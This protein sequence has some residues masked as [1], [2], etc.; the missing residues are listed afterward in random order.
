M[1]SVPFKLK[2]S[3]SFVSMFL[4]HG[5]SSVVQDDVKIILLLSRPPK[6]W[7]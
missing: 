6:Y 1:P 2:S 3:S 4:R 7:D 5:L